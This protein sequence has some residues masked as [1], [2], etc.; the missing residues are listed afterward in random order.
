MATQANSAPTSQCETKSFVDRWQYHIVSVLLFAIELQYFLFL[1]PVVVVKSA[2]DLSSQT[3]GVSRL[4][5]Y[6]Y[7][8]SAKR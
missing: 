7:S 4:L 1:L 2:Y 3:D 6:E 8:R 5:A